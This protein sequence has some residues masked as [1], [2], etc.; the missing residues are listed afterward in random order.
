MSGNAPLYRYRLSI[1]L[2]DYRLINISIQ[3]TSVGSV[4]NILPFLGL[5]VNAELISTFRNEPTSSV[6]YKEKL[7]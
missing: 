4:T 7:I 5:W 3:V 1:I 2:L 6:T